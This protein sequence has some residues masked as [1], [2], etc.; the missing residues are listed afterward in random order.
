[1]K[2]KFRGFTLIEVI[3]VIAIIAALGAVIVPTMLGYA[4]DAKVREL[5]ANANLVYTAAQ[6]ALIK[7]EGDDSLYGKIFTGHDTVDA[8]AAD[9]TVLSISK[10]MGDA[11]TGNYSFKVADNELEIECATW[12]N[13]SQIS[14]SETKI[15]T[16][17]EIR[18][19]IGQKGIGSH[20]YIS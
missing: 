1:M 4:K 6:T 18:D 12:C 14:E 17:Q 16:E 15:Y 5:T 9:G 11:L 13:D 3:V 2:T 10:Y 7:Y 19:S 20:P 8:V